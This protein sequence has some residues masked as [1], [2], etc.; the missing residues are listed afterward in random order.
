MLRVAVNSFLEYLTM[1]TRTMEAFDTT[2]A[3][4]TLFKVEEQ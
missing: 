2:D 1:T 4:S 3:F